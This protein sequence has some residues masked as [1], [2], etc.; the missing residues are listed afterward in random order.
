MLFLPSSLTP[1]SVS[2]EASTPLVFDWN[3]NGDTTD[4]Y[5]VTI[6]KNSDSTLTYDSTKL[7][8]TATQHT[9]PSSS[10]ADGTDYKWKIQLWSGTQ[11]VTSD[12]VFI[13][14]NTNPV[15]TI[16]TFPNPLTV[17]K[18]TF[19]GSYAQVEGIGYSKYKFILY[20][21]SNNII[22]DS[23]YTYSYNISH[24]FSGFVSGSTYSV[25]LI[26]PTQYGVQAT[27]GKQTFTVSYISPDSINLI[28]TTPLDDTG[29]IK[30]DWSPIIQ[31]AGTVTG[32]SSYVTGKFGLGL[33]LPALSSINYTPTVP[34]AFTLNFY[35][36]LPAG[37]TG[38]IV[39]L[40]SN[41]F[42]FGYNG[43]RFYI[44]YNGNFIWGNVVALPI[45]F[46]KVGVKHNKV[47]IQMDSSTE[48]VM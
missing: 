37:F 27:S 48:Y 14:A 38:D 40:G 44:N 35:V 3:N 16:T 25:E 20:D 9:V 17:Q 43:T 41:E 23:G 5:Q 4:H 36:K 42:L 45:N 33:N 32:T 1:N 47:I 10:L 13:K 39:S 15:V 29:G 19:T 26:I 31:L 8:S 28:T 46:F 2:V 12:Y 24:T 6:Y 30:I 34:T 11:T 18:Y 21:A 7:T 22:T